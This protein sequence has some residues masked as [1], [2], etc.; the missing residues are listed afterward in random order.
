MIFSGWDWAQLRGNV[1]TTLTTSRQRTAFS[2]REP[3]AG[4]GTKRVVG[5]S[6][7]LGLRT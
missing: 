4:A 5:R 6:Q 7:L 1:L 2:A 3:Y